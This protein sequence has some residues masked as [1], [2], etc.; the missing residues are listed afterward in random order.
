MSHSAKNNLTIT[1][2]W[3]LLT[4][5]YEQTG[6]ASISL[7][8]IWFSGEGKKNLDSSSVNQF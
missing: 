4:C 6:I 2:V 5:A 1:S 7:Q 8:S 3:F